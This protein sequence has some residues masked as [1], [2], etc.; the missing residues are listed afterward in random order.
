MIDAELRLRTR[1]EKERQRIATGCNHGSPS[2]IPSVAAAAAVTKLP[3]YCNW[4]QFTA[5]QSIRAIA[6]QLVIRRSRNR[7]HK[8]AAATE[9]G[10][11]RYSG[12]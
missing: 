9:M 1:A 2:K 5:A 6:P 7:T 4:L 11:R 8:S 12:P 10:P 3:R